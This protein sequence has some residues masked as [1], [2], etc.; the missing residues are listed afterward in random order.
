MFSDTDNTL[1]PVSNL[2][3]V[4][5]IQILYQYPL[6][7]QTYL[8]FNPESGIYYLFNLAS[9]LIFSNQKRRL[10]VR[11]IIYSKSLAVA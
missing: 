8:D 6:T 4:T 11:K 3:E 10:K 2:F 9:L 1:Y 5:L 7:H